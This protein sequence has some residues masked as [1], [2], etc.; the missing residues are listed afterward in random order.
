[1]AESNAEQQLETQQ[2]VQVI[3]MAQSACG[4]TDIKRKP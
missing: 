3:K 4:V 2:P 1:M